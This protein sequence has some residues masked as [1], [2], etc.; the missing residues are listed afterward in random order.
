MHLERTGSYKDLPS[1]FSA[2]AVN[3]QRFEREA[4]NHFELNHPHICTVYDV[5]SLDG[6]EF[7]VMECVDAKA[8]RLLLHN[9]HGGFRW[10]P[11]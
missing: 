6:I 4:K 3:K 5:G 10:T 11:I 9:E 7:L 8:K 1:Q 2:V